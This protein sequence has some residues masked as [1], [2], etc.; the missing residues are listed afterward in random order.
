MRVDPTIFTGLRGQELIDRTVDGVVMDSAQNDDPV[1]ISDLIAYKEGMPAEPL[2]RHLR[3]EPDEIYVL[4]C[5]RDE[6]GNV[7]QPGDE[8]KLKRMRDLVRDGKPITSHQEQLWKMQGIYEQKMY[9]VKKFKV[10]DKGCIRCNYADAELFL[11]LW[12]VHSITK[13]RISQHTM[14][15]SAEPA[16]C[17]D[18][19]KKHVWYWRFK[20]IEKTGYP[21]ES[22]SKPE[23]PAGNKRGY[24]K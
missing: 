17:P 3:E 18:G 14:E 19:T 24:S 20:E 16:D 23:K 13:Q 8:V 5:L 12:G 9:R 1:F 21:Y 10:D 4:H 7:P 15:H 11:R 22:L 2:L 6:W